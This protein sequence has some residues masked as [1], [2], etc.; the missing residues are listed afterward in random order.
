MRSGSHEHDEHTNGD[1]ENGEDEDMEQDDEDEMSLV[2]EGTGKGPVQRCL[3]NASQRSNC[4]PLMRIIQTVPNTGKGKVA[5]NDMLKD[6]WM[7][8]F[9]STDRQVQLTL[10][11]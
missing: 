10:V 1:K 7:V 4:I 2:D 3:S 6:G 5:Q 11:T 8:H 9:S